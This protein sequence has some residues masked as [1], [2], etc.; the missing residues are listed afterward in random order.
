MQQRISLPFSVSEEIEEG[1]E[2][3]SDRPESVAG[4]GIDE[5]AGDVVAEEE[6]AVGGAVSGD[7]VGEG[8]EGD[9]A[10]KGVRI[11]LGGGPVAAVTQL[12]AQCREKIGSRGRKVIR[13]SAGGTVNRG[14]LCRG[15]YKR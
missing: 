11:P 13:R 2:C 8:A 14:G 3:P 15:R 12:V 10:E 5:G 4:H 1:L 7:E 9:V 6:S